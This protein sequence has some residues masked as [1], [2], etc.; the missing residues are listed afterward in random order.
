MKKKSVAV[1]FIMNAIL[2]MSNFIFPLISFPYVSR[3]L[4]PEGTGKISVATSFVTYFVMFAQ[5]GIPTYGVRAC[6]KV[7]DD[8][9][10]LSKTVHELLFISLI[11]TAVSYAAFLWC[12]FNVKKVSNERDLYI[13][14]SFMI[15]LTTIG[16]EWLYKALEQ[17]T[18]ITIRSIFFKMISLIFMFALVHEKSDYVIYG[19][20]TI[21]ASS[22]SYI[23]NLINARKY[24][25]FK[26][27]GNY[28]ITQHL[29]PV[30][31]FFAMSC[32]TTI[33]TNIDNVMLGFIAG[34]VE[35][36]YY[37]AAVKVKNIL[38]SVVTSLGT[39]LLPRCSYYVSNGMMDEFKDI[40]SKAINFVVLIA[41]PLVVYFIMFSNT[42]IVFLSGSLYEPA[43]LPMQII[44]PTVLLIGLTNIL[45]IQILIPLGKE[46]R[47]L[48]SEIVGAVVDVVVNMILIN[49]L[50]SA[51]VAIGTL[52]AEAGVLIVQ[53]I[54]TRNLVRP[55]FLKIKYYKYIMALL[56]ACII[57]HLLSTVVSSLFITLFVTACGFFGIYFIVLIIIKEE[58]IN[59]TIKLA[60]SKFST[61]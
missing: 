58:M 54:A 56:P 37:G 41:L 61:K 40:C 2:T 20:I 10:K 48:I 16:V 3:I 35:A 47:V 32:A 28:N 44:M 17:Y 46:N 55:F 6:A 23:L 59:Q 9:E 22:A 50:R 60:L 31:V 14:I 45:G 39:V 8:K 18:Y 4:L 38:V 26:Y 12:L 42:S 15:I 34:D 27:I 5:L 43:T 53:Y 51:G 29:K 30:L 25:S 1:N 13:V 49:K 11:T 33:Y 52:C 19:G 57:A 36:G 21:F 24:I 7:R